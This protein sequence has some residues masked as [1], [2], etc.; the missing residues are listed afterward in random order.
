MT[1]GTRTFD[2]L[3]VEGNSASSAAKVGRYFR[4]TWNGGDRTPLGFKTLRHPLTKEVITV[5]IRRARTALTH[6]T[7][8]HVPLRTIRSQTYMVGVLNLVEHIVRT[9]GVPHRSGIH[10]PGLQTTT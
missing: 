6:P 3:R 8:T 10:H 9:T 7:L 5:P 2:G 4:K 1:T